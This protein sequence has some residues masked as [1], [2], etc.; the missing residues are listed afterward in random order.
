[1]AATQDAPY[2]L[3][4]YASPSGGQGACESSLGPLPAPQRWAAAA[5]PLC[6]SGPYCLRALLTLEEKGA[7]YQ[8]HTVNMVDKP[9]WLLDINPKGDPLL[10]ALPTKLLPL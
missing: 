1:M 4:E 9:Q 8:I 10:H 7:K 6:A 5:E 3:Y 2:H